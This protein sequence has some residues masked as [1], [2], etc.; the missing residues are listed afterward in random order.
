MARPTETKRTAA[1][2]KLPTK[3]APARRRAGGGTATGATRP[4]RPDEHAAPALAA[5]VVG[6]GRGVARTGEA[7]GKPGPAPRSEHLA[8]EATEPTVAPTAVSDGDVEPAAA[9]GG[10]PAEQPERALS[11]GTAAVPGAPAAGAKAASTP[12]GDAA[13]APEPAR[14]AMEVGAAAAALA[15]RRSLV[16][17]TIDMHRQMVAFACRQTEFGL[18]AGCAMLASRSL[19]EIVS[20]QS[21][22]VGRS[23]ENALANTL[24]LTR[25]SAEILRRGRRSG[26]R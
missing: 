11:A 5:G 17:G 13:P 14:A 20:L 24:E 23:V 22:F 16:E 3:R 9:L 25:L 21:A 7:V 8:S 19:P 26:A 18:A 15:P 2:S 10:H 1:K 12:P 6:E 4:Q